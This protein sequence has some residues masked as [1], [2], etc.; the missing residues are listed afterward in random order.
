MNSCATCRHSRPASDNEI[1]ANVGDLIFLPKM[2]AAM[3][4]G[5]TAYVYCD[6]HCEYDPVDHRCEFFDPKSKLKRALRK[7]MGS[8]V[9]LSDD[10]IRDLIADRRRAAEDLR[11]K[12]RSLEAR[13]LPAIAACS[14][15]L[16]DHARCTICDQR[17]HACGICPQCKS[18]IEIVVR[19][20]G[21]AWTCYGCSAREIGNTEV[22]PSV[23]MPALPDFGPTGICQGCQ[24]TRSQRDQL[25]EAMRS[26]H[27][28]EDRFYSQGGDA[29]VLTAWCN[30]ARICADRAR[31]AKAAHEVQIAREKLHHAL[32][33]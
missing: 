28:A 13:S 3:R 32:H 19:N 1:R 24:D 17:R 10:A 18:G 2:Q 9:D 14:S 22:D 16:R 33:K 12:Q 5:S 26:L 7:R 4:N 15:C 23:R 21:W 20:K 6:L 30:E 31:D 8:G 11:A 25:V 29:A 27:D